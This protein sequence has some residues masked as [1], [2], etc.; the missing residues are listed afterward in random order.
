MNKRTQLALETLRNGGYFKRALEANFRGHM[1]F[2]TRLYESRGF[3]VTGCGAATLDVV[4]K[5]GLVT[6]FTFGSTYERW[7]YITPA[8]QVEQDQRLEAGAAS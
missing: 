7:S 8:Q 3:V 4:K 5:L 2:V 6:P 1:K